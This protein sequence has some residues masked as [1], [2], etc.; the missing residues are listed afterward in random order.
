MTRLLGFTAETRNGTDLSSDSSTLTL[1][2]ERILLFHWSGATRVS[3]IPNDTSASLY[4]RAE[5]SNRRLSG[6]LT[7][8]AT[9]HG[10][11]KITIH[12]ITS[13]DDT[14]DGYTV[15]TSVTFIDLC[16][17]ETFLLL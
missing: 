10:V 11:Y 2:S 9:T 15:A 7:G 5:S 14:P 4:E 12:D 3:G 16:M 6:S 1:R 13:T 17:V 8:V